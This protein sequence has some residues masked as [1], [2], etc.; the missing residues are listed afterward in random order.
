[1]R[2]LLDLLLSHLAKNSRNVGDPDFM[3]DPFAKGETLEWKCNGN[4]IRVKHLPNN[5]YIF[6]VVTTNLER[7]R[8]YLTL[9]EHISIDK[10]SWYLSNSMATVTLTST[11]GIFTNGKFQKSLTLRE[12]LSLQCNGED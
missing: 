4:K 7:I 3:L 12:P 8:G 6:S 10:A 11:T 2:C 5:E 9:T 1:M